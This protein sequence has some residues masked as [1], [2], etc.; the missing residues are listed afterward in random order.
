MD[1]KTIIELLKAEV[2]PTTG[3]TEPGAVALAT[4]AA[5]EVLKGN[6]DN[7]V[8]TVNSNIYKNGVAVGIPG[9]GATGLTIAAALG[10]V[11]KHPEKQL[12]VLESVTPAE[13]AAANT[14]LAKGIVNV[15]V[16]ES[17]TGLYICARL[18][19]GASYS[20]VLI[21]DKH[22]NIVRI[23]LNGE[24]LVSKQDKQSS[25]HHDYRQFL[26][27]ESV[28]I[29]QLV[30][31]VEAL[32][33]GELAFLLEGV[34]MNVLAAEIGIR[35]RLGMRIGSI[36]EEMM[37][38]GA[39]SDD[40][41]N[42][43]KR[44]TAAAADARMSGENV[45]IMSSAGS[46]NHGITAILPVYAVAKKIGASK[47]QLLRAVALSHLVT[48]YVKIYTGSLSALCGCAVAAATA[49]TAAITWLMGGNITMIESAMK[50][51]IA[52]LTGMICDGGKVGCSLKLST[53]AAA[54]V[55][56]SLLAQRNIVVPDTNGIITNSIERTIANLGKVSNPGMLETDKVILNVIM[57]K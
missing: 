41:I 47:E 14:M 18:M 25:L 55:E 12:S 31:A 9:T 40:M 8:V 57:E 7:I 30:A 6:I 44:L 2:L 5:S 19:S 52:N 42:S 21:Q 46:G 35:K 34:N 32:P 27:D 20:E 39:V 50:N 43:A 45:Q 3:C 16:D 11:K 36:Y 48:I 4:A 13:L 38:S 33:V 54:A 15:R 22:T 51:I 1:T 29:A 24:N 26:R 53:A 23:Q 17:K 37:T 56:S 10:A 49:A 28:C